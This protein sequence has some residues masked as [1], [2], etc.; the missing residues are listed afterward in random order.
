MV[1]G[2]HGPPKGGIGSPDHVPPLAGQ[3]KPSNCPRMLSRAHNCSRCCFVETTNKSTTCACRQIARRPREHAWCSQ[4][5]WCAGKG[6]MHTSAGAFRFPAPTLQRSFRHPLTVH[7]RFSP[8]QQ[9][10]DCER[11]HL[12]FV[13]TSTFCIDPI[14]PLPLLVS[15]PLD[16]HTCIDASGDSLSLG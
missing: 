9:R 7:H 6:T 4:S 8:A 14:G 1:H 16:F 15:I 5:H 13:R 11:S 12:L 10:K 3:P 2:I